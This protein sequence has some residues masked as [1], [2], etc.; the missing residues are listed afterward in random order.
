MRLIEWLKCEML[1][2]I[3]S[4]YRLVL[5]GSRGSQ[6]AVTDVIA[7]I[8]L[9]AYLLGR[10]MGITFAAID[11]KIQGKIKLGITE[12]HEVEKWYGDLSELAGYMNRN[13]E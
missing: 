1:S 6:E 7:N 2:G 12:G 10:R 11:L 9:V 4:L 5:K 13:R 8:I 3:S